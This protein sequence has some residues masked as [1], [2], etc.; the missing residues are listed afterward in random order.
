L[1]AREKIT[2]ITTKARRLPLYKEEIERI[3]DG[4]P[5]SKNKPAKATEM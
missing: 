2:E 4:V 1:E 3:N 5:S